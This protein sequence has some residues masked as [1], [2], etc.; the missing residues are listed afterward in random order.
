MLTSLGFLEERLNDLRLQYKVPLEDLDFGLRPLRN[1]FDATRMIKYVKNNKVIEVYIEDFKAIACDEFNLGDITQIIKDT[2][3]TYVDNR[4]D[5]DIND[6]DFIL[7]GATD[8][9]NEDDDDS[10]FILDSATDLGSVEDDDDSDFIV[11]EDNLFED[12]DVDMD[13]FWAGTTKYQASG[14]NQDQRVIDFGERTCAC[15]RWDLTGM[16]SSHAMACI[17]DMCMNGIGDGIPEKWV[18]EA[19]W[20]KTWKKVY[21]YTIEP[22]NGWD[23]WASSKSPT[24]L[25]APKHHKQ[26]GRPKKERERNPL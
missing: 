11:D 17:W 26:I 4:S 10:N 15:R 6:S 16:T 9:R 13:D 12:V 7:D 24:I 2:Q 18:D 19:Y 21:A 25:T 23:L 5:E 1:N 14:P 22:I 3:Y 20:L 8:Q